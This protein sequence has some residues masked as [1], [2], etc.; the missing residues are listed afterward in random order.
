MCIYVCDVFVYL[1]MCDVCVCSALQAAEDALNNPLL[2]EVSVRVCIYTYI[3]LVYLQR[4]CGMYI[5]IK[6]T[7]IYTYTHNYI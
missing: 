6:Y 7:D 1:C 2:G 3:I 4:F 5:S